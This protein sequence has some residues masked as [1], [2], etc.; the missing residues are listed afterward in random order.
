MDDDSIAVTAIEP[1]LISIAD[2]ATYTGESVWTV[3]ERLRLGIYR[4]KKSGRRTLVTL[5][6]VKAFVDALPDAT[7]R[8]GRQ[9][10]RGASVA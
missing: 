9:R 5:E 3:K 2:A 1:V 4:A 10:K 7:F 8:P 6:S